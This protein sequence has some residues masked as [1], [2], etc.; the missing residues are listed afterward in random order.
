MLHF[1]EVRRPTQALFDI[2]FQRTEVLEIRI[3]ILNKAGKNEVGKTYKE[4]IIF[5]APLVS[6]F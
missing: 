6:T 1:E 2:P 5:F 3:K 4:I